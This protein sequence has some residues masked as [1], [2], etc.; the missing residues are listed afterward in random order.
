MFCKL[1]KVINL[2]LLEQIYPKNMIEKNIYIFL[3]LLKICM[4][5]DHHFKAQSSFF[6]PII[7]NIFKKS[8][9]ISI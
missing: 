4:N 1:E 9:M 5:E 6:F 8:E 3:L 2:A 7:C